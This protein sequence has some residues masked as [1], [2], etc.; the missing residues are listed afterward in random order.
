MMNFVQDFTV[1]G[2]KVNELLKEF[3]TAFNIMKFFSW[4]E[5]FLDWNIF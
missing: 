4:E 2:Y 5:T 1:L 3:F